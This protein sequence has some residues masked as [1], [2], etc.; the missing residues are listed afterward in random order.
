[1]DDFELS[2]DY[3]QAIDRVEKTQPLGRKRH[4]PSPV[5]LNLEDNTLMEI[6]KIEHQQ[7]QSKAAKRPL[8]LTAPSALVAKIT[9]PPTNA[10]IP[11]VKQPVKVAPQQSKV[12]QCH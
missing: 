12:I 3:L 11:P 10:R 6:D 5:D 1:M 8:L 7:H 2:A 9:K 4:S